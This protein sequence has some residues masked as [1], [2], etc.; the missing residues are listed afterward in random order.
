MIYLGDNWPDAYRN[1]IYFNN[2][3]GNRINCDV[4]EPETGSG[5]VGHHGQDLMLAND[6]YYR[7]INLRY[8]PDGSVYLIDWYDKNACHRTNP[9]IWDRSNGRIFRI[10]YGDINDS[11]FDGSSWTDEQLMAAHERKNDWHVRTARRLLMER[12]A[13]SAVTAGLWTVCIRRH[14]NS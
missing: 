3:H 6:R 2:I 7:G 10:L 4:L 8:G 1:R 11:R 5:F 13:S 12:G 14:E 9:E